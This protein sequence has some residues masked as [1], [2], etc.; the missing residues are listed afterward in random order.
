[1]K[2]RCQICNLICGSKQEYD[3]HI[4]DVH[5]ERPLKTERLKEMALVE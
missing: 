2:I 4:K 3:S 1:M 5:K